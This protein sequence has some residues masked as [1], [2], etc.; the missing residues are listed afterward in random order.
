LLKQLI[1][2]VASDTPNSPV[3]GIEADFQFAMDNLPET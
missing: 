2:V 3:S 1:T